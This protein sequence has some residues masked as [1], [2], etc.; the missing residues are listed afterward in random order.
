[1]IISRSICVAINGNISF[2]FIA[3]IPLNIFTMSFF[4]HSSIDGHLYYFHVLA[5]V[6][7]A[8]VNIGV[9]VSL[10]IRVFVFS[11]YMP[12]NGIAGSYGNSIFS[13]LKNLHIV[14]NSGCSN[15]RSQQQCRMVPFP[16]YPL[17]NLFFV[18]FWM[19]AILTNLSHPS[20][21]LCFSHD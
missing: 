5:I 9:R 15:L 21:E 16:P 8:A 17:Q 11:M 12:R 20:F 7:S 1:M 14:F 18:E 10:Q 19:V 4:I 13:F 2:I 3:N 6:N